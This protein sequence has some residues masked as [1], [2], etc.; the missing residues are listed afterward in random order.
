MAAPV[1]S[2]SS[3]VPTA[4][5]DTSPTALE[6]FLNAFNATQLQDFAATHNLDLSLLKAP[7]SSAG[8]T[9]SSTILT[10]ASPL[11]VGNPKD[12]PDLFYRPI[13]PDFIDPESILPELKGLSPAETIKTLVK[14]FK[15]DPYPAN[16]A[17][18]NSAVHR[19]TRVSAADSEVAAAIEEVKAVFAGQGV[20]EQ[21]AKAVDDIW[22][23]AWKDINYSGASLYLDMPPNYIYS[24]YNWVGSNMNDAISSIKMGASSTELGGHVILFENSDFWGRYLNYTLNS[25]G[26]DDVGYVGS[27]F[28]DITSSILISRRF[29]NETPA[30]PLSAHISQA[31]ISAIV[32]RQQDVR[33]SGNT[34]FTWDL[35][36]TGPYSSSDWH[37]NAPGR[38]FIYL[39]VPIQVNT[40]Q[41]FFGGCGNTF[42]DV[43]LV[44]VRAD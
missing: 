8:S 27:S 4:F 2:Q 37:P 34:T 22:M 24:G 38:I 23:Q 12:V 6:T 13:N 18:L 20:S 9:G 10:N 19:A 5:N 26:E 41:W 35:M 15:K 29:A 31:S 16:R 3:F 28:N 30:I 14:K 42:D 17:A 44:G 33:S 39:I 7:V 32:N 40:N 43:T 36:P 25:P 1:K 21:G 11:V